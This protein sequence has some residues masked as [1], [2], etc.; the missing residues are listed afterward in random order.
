M[1]IGSLTCGCCM[2]RCSPSPQMPL[3]GPQLAEQG[4]VFNKNFFDD[5]KVRWIT[6]RVFEGE[7]ANTSHQVVSADADYSDEVVR[8]YGVCVCA[9]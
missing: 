6:R 2:A 5:F 7:G 3:D 9:R 8:V 1:D 4:A